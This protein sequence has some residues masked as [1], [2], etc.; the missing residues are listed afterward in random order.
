[1]IVLARM[2]VL[3]MATQVA[4]RPTYASFFDIGMERINRDADSRIAD[5]LTEATS[6]FSRPQE[7]VSDRFTG[8]IDSV[9][10]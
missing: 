7:N 6:L 10:S 8:S 9:R 2:D 1:M 3:Q 5:E 4:N